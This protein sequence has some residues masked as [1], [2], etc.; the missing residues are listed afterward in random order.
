MHQHKYDLVGVDLSG[1]TVKVVN[2]D[3]TSQTG[4][5]EVGQVVSL[6][7]GTTHIE[8]ATI[9]SPPRAGVV[10]LKDVNIP[11]RQRRTREGSSPRRDF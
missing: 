2:F 11:H 5:A 7:K 9:D 6:K 3:G 4:A 8:E 1:A 10:D